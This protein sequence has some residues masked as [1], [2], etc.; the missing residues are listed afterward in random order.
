MGIK[1]KKI[2]TRKKIKKFRKVIWEGLKIKLPIRK[3]RPAHTDHI[4]APMPGT[5]LRIPVKVG[6]TIKKERVPAVVLDAMKMHNELC[7]KILPCRVEEILVSVGDAVKKG[8]V[9]IKLLVII[10]KKKKDSS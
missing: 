1:I 7:P 5:I 8:D 4:V 6:D 10:E 9:L 2:I 3:P